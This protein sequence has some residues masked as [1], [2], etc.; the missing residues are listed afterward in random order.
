[1]GDIHMLHEHNEQL[2]EGFY[3]LPTE[4]ERAKMPVLQ[5]AE[6]LSKRK[7]GTPDYLVLE[8][9]LNLKIAKQ[10][11]Q[12]TLRSG[13]LALVGSVLAAFITFALGYFI[14]KS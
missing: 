1:M 11:A 7:P 12:A 8:H 3:N 10:Q 4:K 2:S 9:E 5:L 6:L 13:W 14:G